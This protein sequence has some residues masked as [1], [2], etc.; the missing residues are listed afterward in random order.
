MLRG[1]VVVNRAIERN[2][3]GMLKN[4]APN[5]MS[6]FMWLIYDSSKTE[7]WLLCDIAAEKRQSYI[8]LDYFYSIYSFKILW[9][10][11]VFYGKMNKSTSFVSFNARKAQKHFV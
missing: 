10:A 11:Y 3:Q 5:E 4:N 6:I 2:I 1:I 8:D 9:E 7:R